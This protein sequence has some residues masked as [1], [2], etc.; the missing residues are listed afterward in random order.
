[1]THS[2]RL[3]LIFLLI[4]LT[5]IRHGAAQETPPIINYSPMDYGAVNQ[6]WSVSQGTGGVVYIAN[7]GGLLIHDGERWDLYPSPNGSSMRAVTVADDRVYGGY[8]MGFGYWETAATGA[9]EYTSL[10]DRLPQPMI[11]GE[12]VWNILNLGEW[13]LFQTLQRIYAYNVAEASFNIIDAPNKLARMYTI[14]ETVYFQKQGEGIYRLE[15][16]QAVPFSDSE[17]AREEQLVGLFHLDNFLGLLTEEGTFYR[18]ELEGGDTQPMGEWSLPEDV[19]VYCSLQL[20]SG[21]IAVGTISS[22]I[23]ILS[24]SGELQYV[25]TKKN[26]LN[27]NTV[28]SLFEDLN[29]NLWSA[30]DNGISIVNINSPFREYN[31]PNGTLG[32]VYTSKRYQ[33]MLYLGTNQGLFY[34][35]EGS[36]DTFTFIP[37]TRGQVWQLKTIYGTLFC[38]HD[39]GTFIVKGA[40]AQLISDVPGTWDLIKV[41]GDDDLLLQGNYQ[42]LSV[43]KRTGESWSF[44]NTIQGFGVSSRFLEFAGPSLLLVSHEFR[45]VYALEMGEEFQQAKVVQEYPAMGI[46][47]SLFRFDEKLLYASDNGIYYFD[48]DTREFYLQA[49]YTQAFMQNGS[50]PVGI[51]LPD[52]QNDKLW[53]FG[54]ESLDYLSIRTIDGKPRLQ[55]QAI[56]PAFRRELG[57]LGFEN[58]EAQDARTYLVGKSN[59]YVL[60]N[61]NDQ[62]GVLPSLLLRGVSRLSHSGEAKLL[63][64]NETL[65]LEYGDNNIQFHFAVPEYHK[66]TEVLYRYK[67]PGLFDSWSAWSPEPQATF[68]NLSY[69]D[70][71]FI[72]QAKVGKE[73]VEEELSYAF[74]IQRPWYLSN[75]AILSYTVALIIF[76]FLV[77]RSYQAYYKSKESRMKELNRRELKRKK[78]KAKK[79]VMQIRNEKLK[80]EIEGKNRELAVSTMSLI[81]KNE[82]LGKIKEELRK[83]SDSKEVKDVIRTIDRNINNSDDWKFFEE[84]FNNADKDFLKKVQEKH[85]QLTSNDLKLCAYLR[86]NLSSKE[87]APLLNISVRSVEVKRYRLRKKMELSHETGLTEY[88]LNL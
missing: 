86:L 71:N 31:D 32:V 53:G 36:G 76:F 46:G 25:L 83:V 49:A 63:P 9:L 56:P 87:I 66:Y 67:M 7:N 3:L 59:G 80:Q 62:E 24:P 74:Q 16:G 41:P 48:S 40:A 19:K 82:F 14:G 79:E 50:M 72:V 10:Q 29:G 42:G 4:I 1:M 34:K 70:F 57:V 6:N 58:I 84:A 65:K 54:S 2:S 35:R 55:S 13:V 30:L 44:R 52:T 78:L 11:E 77:H 68:D 17:V 51:L 21:E 18:M 23:Y 73:Q 75:V 60:L 5:G 69:G 88:I 15:G 20:D 37:G 27:N 47:T 85:P 61:L 8:Y 81:K 12:E 38:G 28:L 33:G 26:G 64:I 39:T 22:G 43:L 45:G